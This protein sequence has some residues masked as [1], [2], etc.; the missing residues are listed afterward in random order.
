MKSYNI[1]QETEDEVEVI[2]LLYLVIPEVILKAYTPY[3][4]G[5]YNAIY[6]HLFEC[7][8]QWQTQKRNHTVTVDEWV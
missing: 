3:L 5:Q 7:N 2:E 6:V 4:K 1:D 8:I